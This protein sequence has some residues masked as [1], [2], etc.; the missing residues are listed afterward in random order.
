M[1]EQDRSPASEHYEAL[2]VAA[3]S[4]LMAK[5]RKL[6]M[7]TGGE[8]TLARRYAIF[9]NG[10]WQV[11]NFGLVSYRPGAPYR[12]Q[13]DAERLLQVERQLYGWPLYVVQKP[14]VKP[15]QFFEA[16]KVAIDA[17]EGRY[18]GKVDLALLQ[19]SFDE[20]RRLAEHQ[21][22]AGHTTD[23]QPTPDVNSLYKIV[24]RSGSSGTA[25]RIRC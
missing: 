23:D 1:A 10:Q 19:A 3:A 6:S 18:P 5:R 14:W 8:G 21:R 9:Q 2:G 20:A 12:Y 24:P 16:F 11:T 17:H 15:D 4:G 22:P 7:S 25:S 13:I